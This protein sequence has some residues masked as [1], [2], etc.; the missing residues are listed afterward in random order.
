MVAAP[1]SA[2]ATQPAPPPPPDAA[3]PTMQEVH[4]A[5]HELLEKG[6][7]LTLPRVV[8]AQEVLHEALREHTRLLTYMETHGRP[9]A[10]AATVEA[11]GEPACVYT[12]RVVLENA[13]ATVL[14]CI[15]AA[16]QQRQRETQQS[17]PA[18]TFSTSLLTQPSPSTASAAAAALAEDILQC[19]EVIIESL[20]WALRRSG[21]ASDVLEYLI[22]LQQRLA[23]LTA[24]AMEVSAKMQK[25]AANSSAPA[26][27]GTASI[28]SAAVVVLLP[29]W[30]RQ[31]N[32][33][34]GVLVRFVSATYPHGAWFAH[35]NRRA[36]VRSRRLRHPSDVGE[37]PFEV[38]VRAAARVE[39][40]DIT[41]LSMVLL[42]VA[43]AHTK[44]LSSVRTTRERPADRHSLAHVFAPLNAA[45][46]DLTATCEDLIGRRE[47]DRPHA[48]AV[49]EA[50]NVFTWLTTE[51]EPCVVVEEAFGSANT[52][53]SKITARGNVLLLQQQES[54]FAV[55]RPELTK[56]MVA[57]AGMLREI[58]QRVVLMVLYRYPRAVPWGESLEFPMP[59]HTFA[60]HPP[61]VPR[62][63]GAAAVPVW[64]RAASAAAPDAEAA[65][66]HPPTPPPEAATS[67]P[68]M[69]LSAGSAHAAGRSPADAISP[70]MSPETVPPPPMLQSID[71][72]P[73]PSSMAAAA[74]AAP[75]AGECTLDVV[76]Q[77]WT[78]RGFHQPL[79]DAATGAE[80]EPVFVTLPEAKVDRS[81][82]VRI[83]DCF[84]AYVTVPTKVKGVA[85][86]HCQHA[87]L[88]LAGSIGPVRITD[89]ERQE[90]LIE[91]S[92]PRVYA[93]RVTGLTVH[94]AGDR[95]TELVT[96]MATN[97]N[98]TVMLEMPDGEQEVRELALPEQYSTTVKDDDQL[99]TTE[100]K[101]SG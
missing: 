57:W 35:R 5:F 91:T 14:D 73:L 20:S 55:A 44:C 4:L 59:R 30:L 98:V 33:A 32:T 47:D 50:G 13:S 86:E 75:P 53:L 84:N 80:Q 83:I 67:P 21:V 58:L 85:V 40:D 66:R 100:V 18:P 51:L 37:A 43:Q 61:S 49:L 17:A 28:P 77:T 89:S 87:K 41:A 88:Q 65:A 95:E 62:E 25:L 42:Q 23:A 64:R 63:S 27:S 56:A 70:V 39:D 97:V 31:A 6:V 1:A 38:L 11:G 12:F 2:T 29:A 54:G 22:G 92:A 8:T 68:Q 82:L 46:N 78:V 45:L 90:M 76:T 52:Y 72:P 3:V 69:E 99:V 26:T 94:L 16:T 60:P 36:V 101:Y 79:V 74:A 19:M 24:H 48:H 71:A 96:K 15:D 34:A 7:N 9:T 81:H 93:T 10:E